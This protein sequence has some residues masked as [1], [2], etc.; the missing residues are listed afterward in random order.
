MMKAVRYHVKSGEFD[1]TQEAP[2]PSPGPKDVLIKCIATA[3]NPVDAKIKY[4][5]GTCNCVFHFVVAFF[6]D[7]CTFVP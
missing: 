3:L 1:V 5:K 7:M 6:K 2:I 4:W